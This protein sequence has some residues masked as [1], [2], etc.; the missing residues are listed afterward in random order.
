MK[1]LYR[2]EELV[3]ERAERLLSKAPEGSMEEYRVLCAEYRKLLRQTKTLVRVADLMQSELKALSEELGKVSRVDGLTEIYNRR[4]FRE[5]FLQEWQ[6]AVTKKKRI[7]VLMIDI[8]HFKEYND[9]YGH[10][11]GDDCL[12]SVAA[13]FQRAVRRPQDC[14]ARFGGEEFVVLLPN[15][16]E[17]TAVHMAER[18]IQNIA[19]LCQCERS[20]LY[21]KRV[22]ISVGVA[23]MIPA[24]ADQL[25]AFLDE[26]DQALYEAKA[27]GRN[28]FRIYSPPKVEN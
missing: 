20:P 3:V 9:T 6:R 7:S 12:K 19:D 27:A 22:T 2:A 17:E 18:L 5:I 1:S 25:H 10:L 24:A 26:A 4:Y 8:D 15:S 21:K 14:V 23:S 28:C 13:A 11:A 16:R